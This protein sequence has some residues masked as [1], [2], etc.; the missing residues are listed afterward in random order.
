M[1]YVDAWVSMANPIIDFFNWKPIEKTYQAIIHATVFHDLSRSVA[2]EIRS[3][4]EPNF[5]M[6]MD[7]TN[8]TGM[9][10]NSSQNF[11]A[12]SSVTTGSV[13]FS[14]NSMTEMSFYLVAKYSLTDSIE[15]LTWM[16]YAL[17]FTCM[18]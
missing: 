12:Q 6:L 13:S 4:Q 16:N 18:N 2:M 1:F 9:Q 8:T 11:T 3:H 7:T 5:R 10:A 15:G 17:L 14:V